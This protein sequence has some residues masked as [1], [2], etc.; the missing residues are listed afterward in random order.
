MEVRGIGLVRSDWLGSLE[1]HWHRNMK[2]T[3]PW[4]ARI[5]LGNGSEVSSQAIKITRLQYV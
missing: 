4:P 2:A 3:D 1:T 5:V